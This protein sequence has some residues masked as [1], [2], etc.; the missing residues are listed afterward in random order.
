M[1]KRLND[2]ARLTGRT[3][4]YYIKKALEEKLEELEDNYIAES[5]IEEPEDKSW[6]LRELENGDDLEG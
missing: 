3:E 1:E 6:T 5:R 4:S 2:L